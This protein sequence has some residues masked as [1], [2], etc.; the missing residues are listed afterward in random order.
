MQGRLLHLD[1]QLKEAGPLRYTVMR[2]RKT[3]CYTLRISIGRVFMK[4]QTGREMP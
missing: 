3:P 1:S 4:R 2:W